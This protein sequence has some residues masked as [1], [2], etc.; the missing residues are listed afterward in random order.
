[1]VSKLLKRRGLGLQVSCKSFC[2][3][4]DCGKMA[5]DGLKMPCAH[6]IHT[7]CSHKN[8]L[9]DTA[10]S[11]VAKKTRKGCAMCTLYRKLQ[12]VFLIA[13]FPGLSL[14]LLSL[15]V[16]EISLGTRLC[17]Y[18]RHPQCCF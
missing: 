1:M 17:F 8:D 10:K 3:Y 9:C 18:L 11:P 15:A 2:R 13:S 14:R 16:W 4:V 7:C 12:L 5:G 6:D